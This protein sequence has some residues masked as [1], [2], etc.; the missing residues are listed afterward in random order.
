MR[1]KEEARMKDLSYV[2]YRDEWYHKPLRNI[3]NISLGQMLKKSVEMFGNSIA[4]TY[5]DKNLTFHELDLYSDRVASFL[6]HIGIRKGDRVATM[7]PNSLEHLISY[8]GIVKLGAISVPCNIMY[9]DSELKYNLTNS[10]AIAIF[11]MDDLF[12]VFWRIHDE[13]NAK[14]VIRCT[15]SDFAFSSDVR[16]HR[17]ERINPSDN[18]YNFEY[19]LTAKVDNAIEHIEIDPKKDAQLILYTA[20]TTGFPKGVI[21]T[22]YNFIFNL[23]NRS[24]SEYFQDTTTALTLFPM[25]HVSGY[26]LHL[27]L[28]IYVGGRTILSSRF[29]PGK[30]LDL[31]HNHKVNLFVAPPAAFIGMLNHPNIEGCD[32]SNLLI[33]E[34]AGAPVPSTLQQRWR[35]KTGTDLLTG[36]G[37]TETSATATVNL[38]HRKNLE[39]GCIGLPLGGE[40]AIIDEDGKFKPWEEVGEIIF[41]GP[42]VMKGYWK[43]KEATNEVLTENRWLHT[44]DMGY[45]TDSGFVYFVERKKDLIVASGYNIAPAEIEN[46]L[47]RHPAILETAVIGIHHEY[48][49]ET[50]K[51]FVVLKEENKGKVK[52]DDIISWAKENMAAY[53]Y[54]RLVEFIDELPKSHAQKVLRRL[55]RDKEHEKLGLKK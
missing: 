29:E 15:V 21:L 10:G 31:L 49:G 7:L 22:H 37:M 8:F 5:E 17:Y 26:I 19:A 28:T 32:L 36:Y 35:S 4:V 50:V 11:I 2:K 39:P 25:F 33:C 13:V 34:A 55:L 3:P 53:K 54:P 12:E 16:E 44:G 41:R 51:A 23:E 46:I 30:F 48:R 1:K 40:L 14:I 24:C 45:L 20:G 6:K 27:L 38:R 18:V 42:Q 9:K 43:N 47:L 52:E